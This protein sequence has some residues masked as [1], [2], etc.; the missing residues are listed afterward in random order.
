MDGPRPAGDGAAADVL[1]ADAVADRFSGTPVRIRASTLKS[2]EYKNDFRDM[3]RSDLSYQTTAAS[4][5]VAGLGP[6][7]ID[8]L[9]MRVQPI[10][11][12]VSR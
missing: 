5:D 2:G 9:S 8:V 4:Y 3:T 11:A 6:D 12:D 1:A 10:S 7:D